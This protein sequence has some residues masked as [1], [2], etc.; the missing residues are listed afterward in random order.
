MKMTKKKTSDS[1]GYNCTRDKN[2]KLVFAEGDWKK[3]WKNHMKVIMNKEN[4]WN[5]GC[6]SG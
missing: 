1:E 5:G 6:K 3:M 2:G 4:L